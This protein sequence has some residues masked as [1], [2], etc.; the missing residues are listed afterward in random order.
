MLDLEIDV[1]DVTGLGEP[2][3]IA[4]TVT[5][6]DP[7]R[8]ADPPLVCFAKPGAGLARAY[9]TEDL[10][11]PAHGAQAAWH[12]E[13]GWV[14]VAVDNL[15][16][17]ASSTHEPEHTA[18]YATVV[19]AA[20]TAEQEVLAQLR[21]GTLTPELP[22]LA[23][24][25]VVGIG[26]SMGA[27]LTVVQQAHH[28]SYDGIAVLGY[29]VLHTQPPTPPGRPAGV[30]PWR[31]RDAPAT[32]LNEAAVARDGRTGAEH[33]QDATW[34]FCADDVDPSVMRFGDSSAPWGSS[35]IPSLIA[36]VTTPGSVAP[37]AAAIDVPVLLAM[38]DRDVVVDPAG[39]P[40]AY[41]SSSSVDLFVCPTMGHLH[42]FASTR[43]LFWQRIHTWAGWVQARRTAAPMV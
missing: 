25:I 20:H 1:T 29:S 2:A 18:S 8:L 39:E 3:S 17:G 24:P 6:P 34:S 11:G 16:A 9:F 42:N 37:E 35:T 22:A 33:L 30:M 36:T 32:V 23:D 5:L 43:V 10:P 38:G 27:C 4:L 40:R 41:R 19:R 31:P 14:F 7:R 21:A 26:Q 12:A 13:R 28:R 15:G